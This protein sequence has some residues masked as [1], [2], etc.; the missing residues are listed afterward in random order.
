[1][2]HVSG[3]TLIAA[4]LV[5]FNLVACSLTEAAKTADLRLRVDEARLE[6]PVV[7]DRGLLRE[8]GDV[9]EGL[10][11][12]KTRSG[13][14]REF[15][16]H[17]LLVTA[18]D[19]AALEAF[20]RRWNGKVLDKS[21][22]RGNDGKPGG[23]YRVRVAPDADRVKKIQ[24]KLGRRLAVNKKGRV[25]VSSKQAGDVLAIAAAEDGVDGLTVSPR[26][27]KYK[28]LLSRSPA[29]R[30]ALKENCGYRVAEELRLL[31]DLRR[32]GARGA[33]A[34]Q[35][36]LE[37]LGD[38]ATCRPPP[39]TFDLGADCSLTLP[40]R[41]KPGEQFGPVFLNPPAA[42]PE[43][44]AARLLSARGAYTSLY[45]IG[46]DLYGRQLELRVD[47]GQLVLYTPTALRLPR[48]AISELF[49]FELTWEGGSAQCNVEMPIARQIPGVHTN[50]NFGPGHN[51]LVTLC[52]SGDP[53]PMAWS[54]HNTQEDAFPPPNLS[55]ITTG[56]N[57][58]R[59]EGQINTLSHYSRGKLRV[60]Q[61]ASR[62]TTDAAI[63][64]GVDFYSGRDYCADRLELTPGDQFQCELPR[65]R[66]YDEYSW[67]LV[68]GALP[69]GLTLVNP[70]RRWYVEGTVPESVSSGG[71]VQ[72]PIDLYETTFRLNVPE[73]TT[74]LEMRAVEFNVY[75]PLRVW[76]QNAQLR[77]NNPATP[78]TH[79]DNEERMRMIVNRI[80]AG[81][82]DVVALQ[83]VFDNDQR[84]RL[85]VSADSAQY[86]LH[87]GPSKEDHTV[88]ITST[89]DSGL[90]LLV[91]R[92]GRDSAIT[93]F[94]RI[95]EVCVDDDV[96]DD[97]FVNPITAPLQ[98]IPCP[99]I[100]ADD[101]CR[102]YKGVSLTQ[103]PIGAAN[104]VWIVNTHLQADYD[105]IA[106]YRSVRDQ[107]LSII[108]D[109]INSS[110]LTT[111]P[112]ILLGDLNIVADDGNVE[113]TDLMS[114]SQNWQDVAAI[115]HADPTKPVTAAEDVNAYAHF[116]H[117]GIR[118]GDHLFEHELVDVSG[119]SVPDEVAGFLGTD[120]DEP[121]FR[122]TR[123]D[124]IL[125]RQG[126]Q[127]GIEFRSVER[128]DTNLMT[129]MCRNDFPMR[130]H[131]PMGNYPGL[132][133]YLSDHYGLSSMLRLVARESLP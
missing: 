72:S 29:L 120:P 83:E 119:L 94:K 109:L 21:R 1:M 124:Y 40:F 90:A 20:L 11:V 74:V 63:R 112:L 122:R 92:N 105:S 22:T 84:D 121:V 36:I 57:T 44:F 67:T 131:P 101:D 49:T 55:L 93:H 88:G 17:E 85:E 35:A 70:R 59:I 75:R 69:P 127:F 50:Y 41:A 106:E 100:C 128:E 27:R 53:G 42:V 132:R 25:Q 89:E 38:P 14:P 9:G 37:E 68:S 73:T 2:S 111:H 19:D 7:V 33:A 52:A 3:S 82:F 10:A 99:K 39:P 78:N 107:Q 95:F 45:P 102:S 129:E 96:D 31:R 23:I 103:V 65:P 130:D 26:W 60:D 97:V 46:G 61:G 8:T 104:H 76:T 81:T 28:D 15:Y 5:C 56:D 32:G 47:G 115:I 126:T 110:A 18:D 108:V 54:W 12:M 43:E 51:V 62:A 86:A 58:A 117:S 13:V 116:W 66:G 64:V 91:K 123:L 125:V 80:N 77:P 48:C 98:S 133:C 79:D 24:K 4:V 34:E 113:Y 16:E 71:S 114:S 87:L 118:I 6:N 30:T